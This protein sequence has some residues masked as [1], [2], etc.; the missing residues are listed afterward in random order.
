MA[1]WL[2]SDSWFQLSS[3]SRGCEFRPLCWAWNLLKKKKKKEGR[4]STDKTIQQRECGYSRGGLT[5]ACCLGPR[6]PTSSVCSFRVEPQGHLPQRLQPSIFLFSLSLTPTHTP[7]WEVLGFWFL[8]SRGLASEWNVIA[9]RFPLLPV[10][11]FLSHSDRFL[12]CLPVEF[13]WPPMC[14]HSII[15]LFPNTDFLIHLSQWTWW[16]S[17]KSLIYLCVPEPYY[18]AWSLEIAQ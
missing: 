18:R 9:F 14:S 16:F 15:A 11:E 8:P 3:L 13:W 4:L 10:P 12:D 2:R 5:E 7:F 6:V 1:Q 17:L